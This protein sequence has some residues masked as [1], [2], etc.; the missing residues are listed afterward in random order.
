MADRA[1]L[2]GIKHRLGCPESRVT[3][4]TLQTREVK[5]P[6]D[7][8]GI[9]SLGVLQSP[10]STGYF[11]FADAAL[12]GLRVLSVADQR[13]AACLRW[14]GRVEVVFAVPLDRMPGS[15]LIPRS[16]P[17]GRISGTGLGPEVKAPPQPAAA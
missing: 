9:L 1:T 10:L 3:L 14:N 13:I 2:F 17:A 12:A 16:V 4:V 5:L 11:L 15:D 6:R 7:A 8:A